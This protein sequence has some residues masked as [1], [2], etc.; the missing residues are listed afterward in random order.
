MKKLLKTAA[1]G[2]GVAVA[3]AGTS[4]NAR[5][6]NPFYGPGNSFPGWSIFGP[7]HG[8]GWS[9]PGAIPGG[10]GAA[11]VGAP[12]WSIFGP[13]HGGGWSIFGP[14]N[15]SGWN[16]GPSVQGGVLPAGWSLIPMPW[17]PHQGFN[18]GPGGS[19]YGPGPSV[20]IRCDFADEVVLLAGSVGDCESAGG[21]VD[22]AL[23]NAAG[24][25]AP[26]AQPAAAKNN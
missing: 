3:L 6:L 18:V 15:G 26:A 13:V 12:G 20:G 8:G 21:T 16:I 10:P 2:L 14:V 25:Q 17:W 4:A 7:V 22:P 19:P 23:K 11:P 9:L 1:I 5:I 24:T